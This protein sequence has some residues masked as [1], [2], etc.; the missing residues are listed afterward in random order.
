MMPATREHNGTFHMPTSHMPKGYPPTLELTLDVGPELAVVPELGPSPPPLHNNEAA[1]DA[2]AAETPPLDAVAVE[3]S[4]EESTQARAEK[5]V[6]VGTRGLSAGEVIGDMPPG[7]GAL[8]KCA[9]CGIL[10]YESQLNFHCTICPDPMEEGEEEMPASPETHIDPPVGGLSLPMVATTAANRA[11]AAEGSPSPIREEEDAVLADSLASLGRGEAS[12]SGTGSSS[13]GLPCEE[14]RRQWKQWKDSDLAQHQE[15]QTQRA[16]ARRNQMVD[17][18]KRK[19]DQECTFKPHILPRGSPRTCTRTVDAWSGETLTVWSQRGEQRQRSNR[20]KQVEAQVYADVTL[21]PRI[22]RFAQEWRQKQQE[23][24]GEG[25]PLPNVFE[26]LYQASLQASSS[27]DGVEEEGGNEETAAVARPD[28]R[29]PQAT[30][31][32]SAG[33]SPSAMESAE[34]SG[35]GAASMQ[36]PPPS[37]GSSRRE[38]AGTRAGC[39]LQTRRPPGVPTS[40]ALYIDALER[41]ERMRGFAEQSQADWATR[42]KTQVLS[43]SRRYYWQM[44]ER[45]IKAAFDTAAGG[46]PL[47]RYNSLE[48]FLVSF[49]CV[50]PRRDPEAGVGD[51]E[52][53]RLRT[54]LWR[55]LDPQK[56]GHVDL[57]TLTVFFHV[58]MGAVDDPTKAS[59]AIGVHDSLCAMSEEDSGGGADGAEATAMPESSMTALPMAS[60]QGG[61]AAGEVPGTGESTSKTT[62]SPRSGATLAAI[63][64]E[65]GCIA[66]AEGA[67]ARPPTPGDDNGLGTLGLTRAPAAATSA[68]SAAVEEESRRICDLLARFDPVRLRTEFQQLYRHRMHYQSH[69][70]AANAAAMERTPDYELILTPEIDAQSRS[71]AQKLIERQK[72]ESGGT[73]QQH[74]E[75]LFWRQSQVEA[76]KEERRAQALVDEVSGCTFRPKLGASST[77]GGSSV[78]TPEASVTL[79]GARG[80]SRNEVLYARG[81]VERERKQARAQEETVTRSK[82]EVKGCTFRPDTAKSGRSY[83]RTQHDGPST[84]VPRGFYECR[85]RL[86]AANEAQTQKRC[87]QEDRLGRPAPVGGT[88]GYGGGPSVQ[89]SPSPPPT[90]VDEHGLRGGPSSP[91]PPV[92][93]DLPHSRDHRR[94]Q[95]PPIAARERRHSAEPQR[96]S[97]SPGSKI[98]SSGSP[99]SPRGARRP[100]PRGAAGGGGGGRGTVAAVRASSS[101]ARPCSQPAPPAAQLFEVEAAAVVAGAASAPPAEPTHFDRA[102]GSVVNSP[103]SSPGG[104]D[105]R[106]AAAA[107]NGGAVTA[108]NRA[109][110]ATTA[111]VIGVPGHVGAAIDEGGSP[112]PLLYV[113]VNIAPGQ[114][115]ERIVLR[116]GESVTEVAAEF[117]AKHVLTPA[118]AQRLHAL[119]SEVLQRQERDL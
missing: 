3:I 40:E 90:P 60:M 104:L 75:L 110:T 1:Q 78:A 13:A 53:R 45:Q 88:G 69:A 108:G 30:L 87:Q 66:T 49:G 23:T 37:L 5:N 35:T 4:A 28:R 76:K 96:G 51:E 80:S 54:A 31:D 67:T 116:E 114:P 83:N 71:I 106:V 84:P 8:Y 91:L 29:S 118:L 27:V 2:V 18:L 11:G 33:S 61:E 62:T 95:S 117:A 77:R 86:R 97:R 56:A 26:R 101:G 82:N 7:T 74:A 14:P 100:P 55:H 44:L 103:V 50:R 20:L 85:Q 65:D 38:V 41:R 94:R 22:T 24:M 63:V 58:L 109:T 57:L 21:R 105:S 32:A 34:R 70:H 15:T 43:R 25:R 81:L 64:E 79:E 16:T 59:Q 89:A 111:A 39:Q 107:A 73:L 12:G 48:D 47:L 46:S 17:E 93:E 119:L 68:P 42:E 19:E 6:D 112:P 9:I 113:D 10:V 99:A 92:A 102:S 72:G 52:S 36:L 98:R 115:P